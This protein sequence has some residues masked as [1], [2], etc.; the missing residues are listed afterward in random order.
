MGCVMPDQFQRAWIVAGDQLDLRILCDRIVEVGKLA[1][2]RHRHGALGKRR[3]DASGDLE[4]GDVLGK[5]PPGAVGEG[6]GDLLHGFGGFQIAE[7][8]M[9]SGLGFGSV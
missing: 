5:F 9:E 4:P 3:R 6:E 8:V 2:E 1:V 7:A